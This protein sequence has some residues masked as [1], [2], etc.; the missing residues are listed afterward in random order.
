MS[1]CHPAA[2]PTP[3][4]APFT[5]KGRPPLTRNSKR[6]PQW[7]MFSFI[8]NVMRLIFTLFCPWD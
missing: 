2:S 1:C 6:Q 5:K 4:T 7:A 8:V 3:E